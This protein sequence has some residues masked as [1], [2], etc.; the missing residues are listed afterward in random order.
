VVINS[1]P[2]DG[3]LQIFDGTLCNDVTVGQVIAKTDIDAGNL[4]F[5]PDANE[6]GYCPVQT[7]SAR[8]LIT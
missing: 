4:C 6:S 1:L 3:L 8:F 7:P 5:G 2:V